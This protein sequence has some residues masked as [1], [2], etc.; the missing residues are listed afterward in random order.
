MKENRLS[1]A[2]WWLILS[3]VISS[4]DFNNLDLKVIVKIL[5]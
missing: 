4:E 3:S 5:E 2:K 1:L